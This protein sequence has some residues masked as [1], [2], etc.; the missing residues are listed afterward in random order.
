MLAQFLHR[1]VVVVEASRAARARRPR[2]EEVARGARAPPRV[3]VVVVVDLDLDR[4][5][6]PRG[7]AGPD[8]SLALVPPSPR[9]DPVGGASAPSRPDRDAAPPA[10]ASA[11]ARAGSSSELSSSDQRTVRTVLCT[12]QSSLSLS[13]SLLTIAPERLRDASRD[14]VRGRHLRVTGRGR[15][16]R[17]GGTCDPAPR[18]SRSW[19]FRTQKDRRFAQFH[20][21]I[22]LVTLLITFV[23]LFQTVSHIA[24]LD[25]APRTPRRTFLPPGRELGSNTVIF[26]RLVVVHPL[27]SASRGLSSRASRRLFSST[28]TARCTRHPRTRPRRSVRRRRA[29]TS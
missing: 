16:T 5:R 2:R 8:A 28:R 3:V 6:R 25:T 4:V 19:S 12:S 27:P 18:A 1:G 13:L 21:F 26:F 17:A 23:H 10:R 9:A 15:K 24:W 22:R 11:A 29:G 7:P 20:Q 14:L